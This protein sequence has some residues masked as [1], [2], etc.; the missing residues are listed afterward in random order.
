M[1]VRTWISLVVCL[2]MSEDLFEISLITEM[3][4][5]K[6]LS[7]H[8]AQLDDFFAKGR[9]GTIFNRQTKEKEKEERCCLPSPWTKFRERFRKEKTS[10][11]C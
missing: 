10:L 1:I 4:F 5:C 8:V 2:E 6:R 3:S 7:Q 9:T 11:S